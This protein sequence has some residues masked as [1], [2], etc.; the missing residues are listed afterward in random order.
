MK[1]NTH[2][3]LTKVQVA[4]EDNPKQV[5]WM[6]LGQLIDGE[7]KIFCAAESGPEADAVAGANATAADTPTTTI[8]ATS[9]SHFE[10]FVKRELFPALVSKFVSSSSDYDTQET[11][12]THAQLAKVDAFTFSTSQEVEN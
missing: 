10:R 4:A 12:E 8:T 3:R 1:K 5:M 9:L 7:K 2:V 6:W 11:H